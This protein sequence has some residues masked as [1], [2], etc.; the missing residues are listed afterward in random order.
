MVVGLK[1]GTS[2]LVSKVALSGDACSLQSK[3][4]CSFLPDVYTGLLAALLERAKKWKQPKCSSVGKCINK[5]W[6]SH[7]VEECPTAFKINK[8]IYVIRTAIS[9]KT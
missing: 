8:L 6:N 9:W 4:V 5:S 2:A 7:S 3:N 1:I